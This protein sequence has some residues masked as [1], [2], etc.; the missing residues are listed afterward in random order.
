MCY[1][2]SKSWDCDWNFLDG[3]WN[4]F[5]SAELAE[6][7]ILVPW[8]TTAQRSQLYCMECKAHACLASQLRNLTQNADAFKL[9][10][11]VIE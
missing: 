11:Q 7:G 10:D 8:C 9:Q 2:H 3:A 6:P 1:D 5:V 4:V